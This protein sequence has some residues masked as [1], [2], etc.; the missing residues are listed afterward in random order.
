VVVVH[1][2]QSLGIG[3]PPFDAQVETQRFSMLGFCTSL[4]RNLARIVSH[5]GAVYTM[6]HEVVPRKR[7]ILRGT[8]SW[9]DFHG[10]S[11]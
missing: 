7:P 2:S 10:P 3:N 8:T 4:A 6:D 1:P 11:Y 9:D 5:L